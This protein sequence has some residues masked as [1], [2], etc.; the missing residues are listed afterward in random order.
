MLCLG[1]DGESESAE[2]PGNAHKTG[3][4]RKT[5]DQLDRATFY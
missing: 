2:K 3:Q 1:Q 5:S 4:P